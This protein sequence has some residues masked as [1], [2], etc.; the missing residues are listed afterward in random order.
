MADRT[1]PRLSRSEGA[2]RFVRNP[3][4]LDD[5][6]ARQWP[7]LHCCRINVKDPGADRVLAKYLA[8]FGT[9]KEIPEYK[10]VAE[11]A[12]NPELTGGTEWDVLGCPLEDW[13]DYQ[14]MLRDRNR[15]MNR[16]SQ[17]VSTEG[18]LTAEE[19]VA[20]GAPMSLGPRVV[21]DNPD[22]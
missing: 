15:A 18:S 13:Q 8:P 14:Q 17:T 20:L 1:K 2:A 22:R 16:G 9:D 6:W 21:R 5:V 10:V 4:H 11:G 7:D 19:T 12:K 3:N